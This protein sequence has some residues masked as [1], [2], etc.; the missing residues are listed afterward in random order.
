MVFVISY[1]KKKMRTPD[2]SL[3][4]SSWPKDIDIFLVILLPQNISC[5]N[6]LEYYIFNLSIWTDRLTNSVDPDQVL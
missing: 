2:K 5:S 6:L 3:F 4:F 1:K